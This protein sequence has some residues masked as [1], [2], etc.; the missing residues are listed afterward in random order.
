MNKQVNTIFPETVKWA[1]DGAKK[2]TFQIQHC[3]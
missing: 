1:D 3:F 2:I